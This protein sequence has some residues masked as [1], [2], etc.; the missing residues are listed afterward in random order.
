M[1]SRQQAEQAASFLGCDPEELIDHFSLDAVT[2]SKAAEFPP[3]KIIVYGIPGIGKT[4]FAA[5]FPKPILIRFEDGAAAQDIPTFPSV[6]RTMEDLHKAVNALKG[7]HEYKTLIIDSLD[8]MEPV[9]WEYTGKKNNN[10]APKSIENFGYGKGYVYADEVWRNIQK[11]LEDLRVKKQM[12]IIAIAH[13]VPVTVDL[14]DLEPYQ[15]YGMKL[16]KRGAALWME[17]SDMALFINYKAHVIKDADN[18]QAKGKAVGT[19]ARVIFT[20]ERPAYQA[21]S[22][23]PLDEEILIGNDVSWSAFHAN[24]AEITEGIHHV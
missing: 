7:R 4:T 24:L 19:G 2:S 6:L 12:N 23:W 10:G 5:T 13:A 20:Q 11:E 22:R 9:V 15:R 1:I 14:P 18:R 16:H 3:Q 17:W 21:K 8:W